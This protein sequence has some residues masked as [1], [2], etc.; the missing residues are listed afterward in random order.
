MGRCH[1]AELHPLSSAVHRDVS[2]G[3]ARGQVFTLE[4]GHAEAVAGLR[5]N[6][7]AL[8]IGFGVPELYG[9]VVRARGKLCWARSNHLVD[10]CFMV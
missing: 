4:T 8:L 1:G 5:L 7:E 2:V 6:R 9:E 3:I 10:A